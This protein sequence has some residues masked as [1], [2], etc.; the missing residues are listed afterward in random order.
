M[1]SRDPWTLA[2]APV[3]VL[4]ATA[5]WQRFQRDRQMYGA[6]HDWHTLEGPCVVRRAG[7][8]WCLYSGGR[9]EGPDY[10][11]SWAVADHPFG[12]WTGAPGE[13]PAVLRSSP[14]RLLGPGH[15]SV[16][17]GPDG[18]DWL[19]YHAWDAEW[20]ARRMCLDRVTWTPDGPRTA[21]PTSEPQSVG[22][23]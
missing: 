23:S 4:D 11:V 9:W 5:D 14:G 15:N 10:G 1:R 2:G 12:P 21:G 6:L 16:V 13:G 22:A 17:T 7:R 19:V 8:L 20:I 18:G 3:A